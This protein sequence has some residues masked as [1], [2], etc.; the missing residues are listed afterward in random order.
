MGAGGFVSWPVLLTAHFM[1]FPKLVMDSNALPGFTNRKLARFV[2]KAALTFEAAVPFFGGKGVVTGNPVRREFFDIPSRSP[3]DPVSVLIFGGSQG[4]RAINNA[5]IEAL[6][7]LRENKAPLT[8]V[9]QSGEANFEDVRKGY[10]ENDW[11]N[12]E[13]RPY[14]SNMVEF[15]DQADVIICRAGATTCAEVAAAGK[16]AI[17]VPFPGAADDHQKKNAEAMAANGAV[18]VLVQSELNGETLARELTDLVSKPASIAEM[19]A[20]ARKMARPDAATV[21]VDIIWGLKRK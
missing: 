15:F 1:G 11:Q 5:M 17:M 20:A 8:I 7:L 14:I 18:R 3:K 13:I 10:E 9:H 19:G 12:V 6:P 4:A 21:T 16:A 2:D